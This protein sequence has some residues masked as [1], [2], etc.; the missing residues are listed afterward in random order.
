MA[1][2]H[3]YCDQTWLQSDDLLDCER[4]TITVRCTL[5]DHNQRTYSPTMIDGL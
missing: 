4:A 2:R 1:R 5:T 3:T